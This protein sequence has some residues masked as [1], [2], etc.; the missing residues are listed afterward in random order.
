M[1]IL[2][3]VTALVVSAFI[4]CGGDDGNKTPDASGSGSNLPACTGQIYDSCNA[5][6]PNCMGSNVC[7][8]Y[9]ASGFSVCVPPQGA[10]TSGGCPAP[11]SGS[12]TCNTMGFCK[13][14]APNATCQAP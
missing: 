9:G 10:C 11:A 1:R 2:A 3:I 6:S 14:D 13:P 7:K 5:A 12:A 8:A 4:A